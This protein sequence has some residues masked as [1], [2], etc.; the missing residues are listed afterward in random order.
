M[1]YIS[2]HRSLRASLSDSAEDQDHR[3]ARPSPRVRAPRGVSGRRSD[4]TATASIRM[5]TARAMLRHGRD[6]STIAEATHLPQA[7]V[8]LMRD[9]DPTPSPRHRRAG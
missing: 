6:P 9:I 3:G 5:L 2:S 7:L 8:E 1:S 4:G